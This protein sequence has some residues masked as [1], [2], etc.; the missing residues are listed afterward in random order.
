MIV[1]FL[2]GKTSA[3]LHVARSVCRR[4]ERRLVPLVQADEIDPETLKYINRLS[5]F[6]FTVA[7]L[8]AK[9][10]NKAETVYVRPETG[11]KAPP[12]YETG[13]D[14]VWKKTRQK[15]TNGSDE[16]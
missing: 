3:T 7:R 15:N 16:I 1:P 12:T 13:S 10:E 5:D 6:L 9:L 2:G 11:S 14:G 4:A 8:A